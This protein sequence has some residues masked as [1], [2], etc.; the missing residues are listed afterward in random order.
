MRRARP[1]Q[2][3]EVAFRVFEVNRWAVAFGGYG[4]VCGSADDRRDY[5]PNRRKV[6]PALSVMG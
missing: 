2:F 3:D 5:L 4:R 1:F 6:R